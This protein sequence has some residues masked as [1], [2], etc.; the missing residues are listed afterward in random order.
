ML[1]RSHGGLAEAPYNVYPTSDG[2][3]A[4]ICNN[5]RHFH[6]LLKAMKREDLE[7]D[8]R[9]A[10]LKSRIAN[11][12]LV[13][14]IVGAWTVRYDRDTLTNLLLA[15]RVP[16]APVRNLSE[17]IND[18]NM[19][20]RGSLQWIDHPEYGRIVVSH[21]PMRYDGVPL[22][23]LKPSSRLG[24]ENAEVYEGWLGISADELERL[25]K[26]GIV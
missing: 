10:D 23:P 24:A 17:V 19:H 26:D 25:I 11:I 3:I 6:A 15:H 8:P 1:F 18:P 4:I 13:D 14:E 7:K 21:S 22:A 9:L 20:A 5:N 16:H 2:Y 12:D